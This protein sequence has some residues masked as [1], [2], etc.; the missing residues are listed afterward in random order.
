MDKKKLLIIVGSVAAFI[1]ISLI[2]LMIANNN[3]KPITYNVTFETSGGTLVS[4]Q[5]VKEGEKVKKPVDPTREGYIFS[6]WSYKNKS[7]DFNLE[8]T[9]NLVLLAKWVE[10]K[11]DVETYIIKFNT[12]GGSIIP[13][14]V[15]EKGKKVEKP[16]DPTKDGYTFKEWTLNE[17]AFDF[18]TIVESDL[19]LKAKW[20]E[21]VEASNNITNTNTFRNH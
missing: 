3:K 4:S 21:V 8:V 10:I 19:E 9:Q 12:D 17:I 2:I 20:E 7:Y 5:Q 11:E 6:E 14:Q 15:V 18:E 1:V 13:D 16:I